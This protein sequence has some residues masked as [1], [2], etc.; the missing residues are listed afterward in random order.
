MTHASPLATQGKTHAS[1]L[2]T[3]GKTQASLLATPGRLKY[4]R[5]PA[6]VNGYKA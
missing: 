3:Q 6:T 1:P 2:A 4:N 5:E